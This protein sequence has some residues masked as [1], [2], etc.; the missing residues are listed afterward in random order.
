MTRIIA[1]QTA[2]GIVWVRIDGGSVRAMD[3]TDGT[4]QTDIDAAVAS[5]AAAQ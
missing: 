5:V 3:W 2:T 4:S 1:T